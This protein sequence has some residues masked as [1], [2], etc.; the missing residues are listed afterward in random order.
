[1]LKF[2]HNLQ[3][4]NGLGGKNIVFYANQ[5]DASF[6]SSLVAA[7]LPLLKAAWLQD[8]II[9]GYRMAL[10]A[11]L[12]A[13]LGYGRVP[14][15]LAAYALIS[16][17]GAVYISALRHL[18]VPDNILVHELLDTAV[19]IGLTG[20]AAL[21]WLWSEGRH[22]ECD[23]ILCSGVAVFCGVLMGFD[24]VAVA[25]LLIYAALLVRLVLRYVRRHQ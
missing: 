16:L 12:G 25:T 15:Y 5:M 1:M 11:A 17:G 4:D 3:I 20:V 8:A 14:A 13:F 18:G 9:L 7:G 24:V 10:A 21:V 2:S 22:Q 6:A 19:W 23:T